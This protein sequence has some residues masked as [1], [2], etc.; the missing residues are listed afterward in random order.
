MVIDAAYVVVLV[1]RPTWATPHSVSCA[2]LERSPGP[3]FL[4]PIH[5]RGAVLAVIALAIV[6]PASTT[7]GMRIM[8][9]AS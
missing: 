4:E 8:G 9:C 2:T 6:G 3:C 7:A 5:H 1:A